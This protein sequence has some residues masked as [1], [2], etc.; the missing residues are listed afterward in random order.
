MLNII[1]N[2]VIVCALGSLLVYG[3]AQLWAYLDSAETN[4][5]RTDF[6]TTDDGWRIAIHQYAPRGKKIGKPIILC[7]GMSANRFIFDMENGPSLAEFLKSQNREVWV[8]ELRGSGYSRRPGFLLSDSPLNWGFDDH[9][10][11]DVKAIIQHVIGETGADSVHWIGHSMGGMLIEAHLARNKPSN[12]ASALALASPTDFSEMGNHAFR[13]AL[14]MRWIFKIV[15]FQSFRFRWLNVFFPLPNSRLASFQYSFVW[16]ISNGG[17]ARKISAIG[18]E[19]VSSSVLWLDMAR[20]LAEKKFADPFGRS[21][22]EALDASRTPLLAIC[23]TKDLMA[24][25]KAVLSVCKAGTSNCVRESVVL[26]KQT[27]SLHDYGH[28]DIL[29]G[30]RAYEEVFPIIESWLARWDDS[31]SH[32]FNGGS[33]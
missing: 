26:G 6:T 25:Q 2:I 8:A 20:F 17:M 19:F 21:Y 28:M 29:I 3:L 22:L 11:Y 14:K 24:P 31:D 12:V 30:D 9:L 33:N 27:G 5:D 1:L 4:Q 7:H 10:N 18:A 32:K 13:Y 23:G 16:K 15:L